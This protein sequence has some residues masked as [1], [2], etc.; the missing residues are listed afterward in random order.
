MN[1]NPDLNLEA[2]INTSQRYF[3]WAGFC[4]HCLLASL[5]SLPFCCRHHIPLILKLF[6]FSLWDLSFTRGYFSD[7]QASLIPHICNFLFTGRIFKFQ[8]LHLKIPK[9]YPQKSQMCS[10]FAFNLEKFT[11][12]RNFYTGSARGARDKYQV[13]KVQHCT[14]AVWAKEQAQLGLTTKQLI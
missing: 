7:A 6:L 14:R 5:T 8:I 11:P 4:H 2:A 9:I 12:D 1:A 3:N 10:F 13:C